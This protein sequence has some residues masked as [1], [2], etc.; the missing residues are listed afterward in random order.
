M[1]AAQHSYSTSR[2]LFLQEYRDIT[3]SRS[4]LV[5]MDRQDKQDQI[6][7]LIFF[8]LL[9]SRRS[10]NSYSGYSLILNG[11]ILSI[12]LIDV[13]PPVP[14]TESYLESLFERCKT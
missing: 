12:L 8:Y 11:A 14:T 4:R 6:V 9:L 10:A 7:F 3:Y 1:K 13:K 2:R 5:D